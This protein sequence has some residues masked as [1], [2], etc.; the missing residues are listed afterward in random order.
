MTPDPTRDSGSM[1]LCHI[2]ELLNEDGWFVDFI[3]D[4][5]DATFRDVARLAGLGVQV[6]RSRPAQWLREHGSSL[7]AVMLCRLPV[8]DQY[9][10]SARRMAPQAR[11]IFD[12]VD[13]HYVREQRAAALTSNAALSRQANRSRERELAIVRGADVTLVV[14]GDERDVLTTEVPQSHIELVSNIH[15]VAGRSKPFS[16]RSGLLFV[17][18]FGHPPNEDAVRWFATNVL[19]LVRECD[20]SIVFHVVGD[21]DHTARRSIERDGIVVHG[22]VDDLGPL[23][24]NCR[25]SVAPLRF[26]AGVKGKVNQAMSHGLPVVVT[27]VAAEGMH[28]QDGV[29]VLI[30]DDAI[31]MAEAVNRVYH[32]ETLWIRLSDAGIDN[33]RRHFSTERA[34]DSLR[35]ALKEHTA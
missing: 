29:D 23:L 25:L 26:G 28:L 21:I 32:D 10:A 27:T 12:T 24:A 15:R 8:A 34:R 19:P 2:F 11:V 33:V 16:A 5:D 7:D 17:G 3:A 13:L 31:S 20:P 18:G 30:E 22:R 1:R 6:H 35:L 14:S 4:D 9:L